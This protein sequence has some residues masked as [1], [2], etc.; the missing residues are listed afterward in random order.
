MIGI[1]FPEVDFWVLSA[2]LPAIH[3]PFVK[4]KVW[5]VAVETSSNVFDPLSISECGRNNHI[6]QSLTLAPIVMTPPFLW[7]QI[8]PQVV[9]IPLFEGG[10]GDRISFF[11]DR[12]ENVIYPSHTLC[13]V[14]MTAFEKGFVLFVVGVEITE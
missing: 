11:I 6:V 3:F 13:V 4:Q 8:I 12:F 7:G 5:I 2:L 9:V 10:V 14:M 1:S